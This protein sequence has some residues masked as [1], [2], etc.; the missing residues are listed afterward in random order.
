[1]QVFP[2]LLLRENGIYH[3]F[4]TL[5]Q[6]VTHPNIYQSRSGTNDLVRCGISRT[7]SQRVAL[8][9]HGLRCLRCQAIVLNP[10]EE[11][12]CCGVPQRLRLPSTGKAHFPE[13]D[14]W[15]VSKQSQQLLPDVA[16]W[17]YTLFEV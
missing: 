12:M 11:L 3:R 17:N 14:I 7:Q 10:F 16:V 4:F 5:Y 1:M 6:K 8:P 2:P 13:A 9:L 15:V